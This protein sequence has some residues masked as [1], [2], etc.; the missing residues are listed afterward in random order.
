MSVVWTK[1]GRTGKPVRGRTARIGMLPLT[2]MIDVVFLLL[3]FFLVTS[4]FAQQERELPSALQT[5]GGGVR[6]S[7]LQ[8]QIVEIRMDSGSP[9]FVIGDLAVR[10]RTD[11]QRI[12][13]QLPQEPGVA[14]RSDADAPIAAVAAAMQAARD[15]GFTKRSYVPQNAN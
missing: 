13:E 12:L 14:V 3:I 8:P 9:I 5:E 10:T 2:S 15:A 7:D 6:A 11:L 1:R 4:N